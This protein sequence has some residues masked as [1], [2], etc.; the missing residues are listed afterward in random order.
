MPDMTEHA[1]IVVTAWA[2]V[3]AAIAAIIAVCVAQRTSA[4][5][6]KH[7]KEATGYQL[8]N[9]IDE[10]WNSASMCAKRRSVAQLLSTGRPVHEE[11]SID[12]IVD[13]FETLAICVQDGVI[14]EKL[15]AN[16]FGYWA[17]HY[18][19]AASARIDGVRASDPLLWESLEA[20][21]PRLLAEFAHR[22]QR[23]VAEITP[24]AEDLRRFLQEESNC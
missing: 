13:V 15:A 19:F 7:A 6:I 11:D 17:I 16:F 21:M 3:F 14:S 18:W 12:D 24:T 5:T 22:R 8:I 23:T 4:S 20:F 9:Q 10:R 1:A 2:T